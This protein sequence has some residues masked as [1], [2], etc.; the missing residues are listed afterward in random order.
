MITFFLLLMFAALIVGLCLWASQPRTST[1]HN[2]HQLT[3]ALDRLVRKPYGSF[4]IVEE[5]GRRKY[6]Q[7]SGSVSEPLVFDLPCS[8]L[9]L[10]ECDRAHVLFRESG[11]GGPETFEIYETQSGRAAGTQTSFLIHFTPNDID[12]FAQLALT[13]FREVYQTDAR[14]R[15]SIIEQ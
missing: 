4:V 10:D 14:I 1:K 11:H 2:A 12:I 15:L 6:L 9:T 7:I 5:P 3:Q 8:A 13:V